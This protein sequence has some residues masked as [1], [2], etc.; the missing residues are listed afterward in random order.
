[1]EDTFSGFAHALGVDLW[2][3]VERLDGIY[4]LAYNTSD[5]AASSNTTDTGHAPMSSTSGT[6]DVDTPAAVDSSTMKA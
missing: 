2:E 4:M 6:P 5:S 1:M 3:L